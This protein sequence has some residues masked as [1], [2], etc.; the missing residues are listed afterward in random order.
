[1]RSFPLFS[2]FLS[3]FPFTQK[4]VRN[5]I[6]QTLRILKERQLT[7]F[8]QL[9]FLSIGN[10]F[11]FFFYY[12]YFYLCVLE[13]E[14]DLLLFERHWISFIKYVSCQHHVLPHNCWHVEMHLRSNDS[15]FHSNDSFFHSNVIWPWTLKCSSH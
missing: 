7:F 9:W 15:F 11:F 6:T 12:Y 2:Y 13:F 8:H 5:I 10:F 3:L 4:Q 14:H 1:M